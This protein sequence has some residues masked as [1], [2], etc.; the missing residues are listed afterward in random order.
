M[1]RRL[2]AL[3]AVVLAVAFVGAGCRSALGPVADRPVAPLGHDG[4]WFTDATGRVVMLRGMNFVEKSA[5]YTPAADGF[6]D[7]D[8]ALLAANG[9]NTVRLGVV[10]GFLMP[11]PGRIDQA[12]LASI[13]STV[14]V[15]ARHGIYALLDFHQ[16]GYGPAT[17]GNGMP[18]WATL[19]DGLPNPDAPFPTYYI[20]NPALQRAFDNF[21]ANQ[22]GPD[23]VPL[24][25]HY[26]D[27]MRTVAARFVSSPNVIGYEAMNEPWPG[28]NWSTCVTGCPALEQSLLAPF[29]ARMTA[30]VRSVDRHRPVLVEP[31]VLFNFGGT[32]TSLPGS[33]SPNVLAT[34]VYAL[35]SAANASVMD[36]S[37]AAAVRDAAAVLV[38]EWGDS[39]DPAVLDPFADQL[40]A[41]LLPWLYWSY[42]GHIVTD[43]KQPLVPPNLN[44]TGLAALTRAYPTVVNGTP[45]RLTFDP[46]TATMDFAFATTRPDGSRVSPGLQ[47][48]ITVPKLRYPTGYAVTADGADVT[49][50]RCSRAVTLRNRPGAPSVSVHIAPAADCH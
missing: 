43:S 11:A 20:Q 16:D 10:F 33:A 49:S 36:R 3:L 39:T 42:N 23:G 31:F 37:V 24:Q 13:A 19:T 6:D 22:P 17:H 32:D 5:P 18:E 34:H 26:A 29:Y 25:D 41:R 35:D 40:D 21:W 45:T 38:T 12:Y 27:A 28:T 14:N 2:V 30:A 47:T 50:H 44:V 4:R 48:V 7:D 8:A 9:F 15:L 46:A 1:T